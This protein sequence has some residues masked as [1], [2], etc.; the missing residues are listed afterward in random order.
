MRAGWLLIATAGLLLAADAPQKADVKKEVKQ[1][2]GTWQMVSHQVDGKPD[3]ALKGAVRVVKGR[4]FT[5]R[6][7]DKV[8]RAGRMKLDPSKEPKWIDVTFTRGP[9]KGK[10][11]RGI[12]TLEGD[13]QKICYGELDGKRPKEFV[14]KP[15]TGHRLV[16]FKRVKR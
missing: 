14:S 13:T 3:E 9:E 8:L 2:Q 10:T 7:G 6:K 5:I 1:L 4:R 12:Y 16:V 15:G 11:R